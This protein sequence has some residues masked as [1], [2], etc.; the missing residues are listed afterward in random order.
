MIE[1]KNLATDDQQD[2]PYAD[3]RAAKPWLDDIAESEKCLAEYQDKCDNIDKQYGTLKGLSGD[4][5]E[6][7]MQI[8]WANLEVLK[9][10]IYSRPP[11]PVVGARFKDRKEVLRHSSEIIERALSTSF[12]AED[13][14]ATMLALRDDLAT[15]ARGV[16]W[17]RLEE[18]DEGNQRVCYDHVDRKD[19]AHQPA[20]KWKEVG[21][22]ARRTFKTRDEMRARFEKTSDDLYL[23]ADYAERKE[24]KDEGDSYS[25]DQKAAVWE[26]WS[27]EKNVVVWVSPGVDQVL[28][29]RE[30]FLKLDGF[31][32]CPKPVYGTLER[33]TLKPIPDYLYYK[34]QIEEINELTARISALAEALRLKGF[35]AGGNEDLAEAIE[36]AMKQQDNN[37]LLIPVPNFAALGGAGLSQAIVWL[38]VEQVAQ[39]IVQL[40]ALRRQIIEDVYQ[41]TGL[42]DIMR[43]ATDP[44]ETLGA[45]QL[46]SQYGSVRIRDR[47]EELVRIARDMTRMAGEIMAE[48]FE[49]QMLLAMSQYDVLP[50]MQDIQAQIA[51]IDQQIMAA[52]T[53][54]D[55]IAQAQQ[56][57]EMAQQ[58]LQQANEKKQALQGQITI[59]AVM[60][61]LRNERMR[62]FALE[63]ETD[64]TIQPD[65][66]AQ[67]QRVTE[68]MTALGGTLAQLAPMVAQ[69]PQTADFA[70]EVLK[71][72]VGPFRAGRALDAAID[73]F[74]EGMKQEASQPQPNPAAE[75]A[76][77]D[78]EAKQSELQIKQAEVQARQGEAQAKMQIEARRAETDIQKTNAEIQKIMMEIQRLSAQI[79]SMQVGAIQ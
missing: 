5:A 10:A 65:E 72:A 23:K 36:T 32:P 4:R 53:N 77:A 21:F 24:G 63:I 50:S 55:M 15:S 58:M 70:G 39:V 41:V 66:N 35:Y 74:V 8:F 73:T 3:M 33:R 12:E 76:K 16:A 56:N 17:L 78:A 48:N 13:I 52:Q 47:Q 40:I 34:D 18:D 64:S 26:I 61:F 49:P 9:P 68:F 2:D 20:R 45:Q 19:F 59:E 11:V 42:S 25:A 7:E 57:P 29:I 14:N 67:K 30:P 69:K 54:P 1:E 60:E 51:Q 6:R 22:V 75:K 43:G 62:P 27:R 71:F 37:A 46:K 28:D 44:N 38:P 79:N 31:F